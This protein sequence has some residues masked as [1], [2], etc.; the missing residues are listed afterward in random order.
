MILCGFRET[1]GYMSAICLIQARYAVLTD[2]LV[3]Q[4]LD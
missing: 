3:R 4:G 1:L 2:N